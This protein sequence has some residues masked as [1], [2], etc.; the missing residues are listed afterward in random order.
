MLVDL[1]KLMAARCESLCSTAQGSFPNALDDKKI[2]RH[3]REFES[4]ADDALL[5]SGPAD[6]VS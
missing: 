2:K 5:W 3:I 4:R 6:P 1:H